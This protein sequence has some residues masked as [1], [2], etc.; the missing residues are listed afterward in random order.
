MAQV[1]LRGLVQGSHEHPLAAEYKREGAVDS[2]R[3]TAPVGAATATFAAARIEEV[4]SEGRVIGFFPV[5]ARAEV[6][7]TLR[8]H[9][10]QFVQVVA[11]AK[12]DR[13][14]DWTLDAIEVTPI[15]G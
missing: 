1:V 13:K 11:N 10:W 5:I 15:E 8:Q 7:E 9:Q 2:F 3:A 6:A 4:D 14:G 12:I